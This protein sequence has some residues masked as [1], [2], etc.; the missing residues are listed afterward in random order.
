MIQTFLKTLV[1]LVAWLVALDIVGVIACVIFDVVPLRGSSGALPYAIWFVLGVFAGFLAFATAGAW[2]AEAGEQDWM[3]RP[4]GM[5]VGNRVL[6]SSLV[7]LLGL[8]ALFWWL[9]WSRGVA[10]EY[11][12]P[13]SMPH[14][15]VYFVSAFG[16]MLV[17][18]STLRAKAAA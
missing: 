9:Y 3:E 1:V 4:G 17:G 12:V 2:A 6:V 8:A 18:R 10:G 14:T 11:F 16:A 15:I 5:A 13:D 7:V